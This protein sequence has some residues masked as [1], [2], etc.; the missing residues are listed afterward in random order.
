MARGLTHLAGTF[1]AVAVI[2]A[3]SAAT[4]QNAAFQNFFFDVCATPSAAALGARCAETPGGTGNVSGDSE[5]S[6]NPS[7]VVSSNEAALIRSK[8]TRREISERL[9]ELRQE[10]EEEQTSGS[11]QDT[12]R[13]G[14]FVSGRGTSWDRDETTE[15]RGSDGDVYGVQLG[16]DYRFTEQ[17]LVGVLFG[18]ESGDSEFDGDAPGVNFIP[19]AD[20]GD[21]ESDS[22]LLALYGSYS[23]NDNVYIDASVGYGLSEYDIKRKAVFQESGRAVPQTNAVTSAEPDGGELLVSLGVGYD[24]SIEALSLGAYVR[25]DYVR[26]WIESYR[27][28]DDTLSGLAMS[29]DRQ[30]RDS[31]TSVLGG[32][33]SYAASMSWGVLIPQLRVQYVHEFDDDAQDAKARYLL[34]PGGAQY[35]FSGSDPDEDYFELAVGLSAVLPG[36]WQPYAEFETLLGYDDLDRYTW[37]VGIR[38]E[39]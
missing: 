17:L 39:F 24:T 19:P 10:R 28:S 25:G 21:T 5:D 9:E 12:A 36:G 3:P 38:G 29:F 16:L 33:G 30:T 4:A 31:L 11:I 6:L 2:V 20:D 8:G 34:D 35:R 7:Q 18:Y 14:F 1:L 27:E 37:V 26:T 22:Y 23:L 15:E 13:W 32:R